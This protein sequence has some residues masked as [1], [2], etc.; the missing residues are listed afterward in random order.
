MAKTKIRWALAERRASE[1]VELLKDTC[2]NLH[3]AGSVR[4][5]EMLVGDIEL[6]ALP[7]F[8]G[9]LFGQPMQSLLDARIDALVRSRIVSTLSKNGPSCKQFELLTAQGEPEIQVDLF[10]AKPDN[11]GLILALRTGPAEFSKKIVTQHAH[12]GYL[13]DG[14]CV[15]CGHVWRGR[16]YDEAGGLVD[17]GEL[18]PTLDEESFFALTTCGWIQP[19][20]RK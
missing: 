9:D 11:L 1:V 10:I 17:G 15:D 2:W 16:Q 8:K 19:E 13:Q 6:V 4:R 3:V 12:G 7:H 5:K 20:Q 18:L 14:L